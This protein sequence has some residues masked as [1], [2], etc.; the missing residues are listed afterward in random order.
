MSL[1]PLHLLSPLL[2]ARSAFFALSLWCSA[3]PSASCPVAMSCVSLRLNS[4]CWLRLRTPSRLASPALWAPL[5][6]VAPLLLPMLV[7]PQLPLLTQRPQRLRWCLRP[8]MRSQL[9][10]C[11]LRLSGLLPLGLAL[12]PVLLCRCPNVHRVAVPASPLACVDRLLSRS[13][14]WSRAW[15]PRVAH[16]S[17]LLSCAFPA[18]LALSTPPQ[19]ARSHLSTPPG[20]LHPLPRPPRPLVLRSLRP[21]PMTN[22]TLSLTHTA[23][24]RLLVAPRPPSPSRPT[25]L[26]LVG[27]L[28]TSVAVVSANPP[29]APCGG[30]FDLFPPVSCAF[31]PGAASLIVGLSWVRAHFRGSCGSVGGCG[32]FLR[33]PSSTWALSGAVGAGSGSADSSATLKTRRS[34]TSAIL[35]PGNGCARQSSSWWSSSLAKGL[36]RRRTRFLDVTP[37]FT[38]METAVGVMTKLIERNTTTPMM[39]NTDVHDAC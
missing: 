28:A 35:F 1:C 19:S 39:R 21:T 18:S 31:S 15:P 24:P 26:V 13:R 16:R 5:V 9:L 27:V 33:L 36:H 8:V 22:G 11:A 10:C 29:S 17:R 34:P 37:L 4:R 23:S 25:P 20:P 30:T 14:D 6:L 3:P 38:G 32:L 2:L 12:A 7:H